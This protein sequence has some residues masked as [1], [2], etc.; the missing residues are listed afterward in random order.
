MVYVP[1]GP[2]KGRRFESGWYV[3]ARYG[4]DAAAAATA[5]FSISPVVA[6]ID[7]AIVENTAGRSTMGASLWASVTTLATRP[8]QF[9]GHRAFQWTWAL[10]GTT[11][12]AANAID[13]SCEWASKPARWPK[14]L[15]TTPVNMALVIRKD[16]AFSKLF[17]ATNGGVGSGP[18]RAM[19][20]PSYALF[21]VR[22]SHTVAAAFLL[23]PVVCQWL[24]D[25]GVV[26]DKTCAEVAA[27]VLA[28]AAVQF[29]STPYHLLALDLYNR[30][31]PLPFADRWAL[32]RDKYVVSTL[33]RI[34]RIGPAFGVGGV[35]NRS[36]R[37]RWIS[38]L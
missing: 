34:G 19:P 10:Y 15:G 3:A 4:V 30:A 26:K 25:T 7:R 16:V 33:A 14:F 8:L 17:G 24:L 9:F 27:Q 22:D 13:T 31:G 29:L 37:E 35:A 20:L 12:L 11:Y 36:L 1:T 5:S 32:I 38:A 23:P 6:S 21:A 18:A 28:P 2:H